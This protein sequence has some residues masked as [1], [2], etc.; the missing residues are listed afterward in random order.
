MGEARDI[1]TVIG[2]AL[3]SLRENLADSKHR[4]YKV[5]ARAVLPLFR[6]IH[7]GSQVFISLDSEMNA[8]PL[9]ALYVADKGDRTLADDYKIRIVSAPRDYVLSPASK[10]PARR[11]APVVFANP[12]YPKVA[13]AKNRG[14]QGDGGTLPNNAMSRM[15]A[16]LAYAG[17]EGAAISSIINAKLFAQ[18]KA[19]KANLKAV[20]SPVILHIAAH[21]FFDPI[22]SQGTSALA[23][24]GE[25]VSAYRR[26]EHYLSGS[27]IAL[28]GPMSASKISHND[29]ILTAAEASYLGLNASELV[30]L[31]GCST[32]EGIVTNGLGVYGLHRS[33]IEAGVKSALI[34]LWQVDDQSTAEFMQRF[35][36]RLKAG[37][38]RSD[39]LAAVQEEFRTGRVQSP[40]GASWKEPYYWAAWQLVG[41]WR[42]IKGL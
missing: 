3:F 41:D 12:V 6:H 10:V 27:G 8:M 28:S 9:G 36:R 5:Y 21:A 23:P 4:L 7:K 20:K 14:A 24:K 16:P 38:G 1:D 29:E 40:S 26:L 11:S 18:E 33:F 25:E 37:D 34:S 19:T 32:G 31:S 22:P 35:Y 39:A 2:E 30:V 15:W 42:P 17:A 13:V